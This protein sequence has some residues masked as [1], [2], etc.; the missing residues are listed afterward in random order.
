MTLNI[1]RL[2]DDNKRLV[3]EIGEPLP[4]EQVNWRYDYQYERNGVVANLFM[5]FEP[6]TAWR[7]RVHTT[8]YAIVMPNRCNI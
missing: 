4:M 7:R 1:S 3:A 6:L 2:F 5:F 8:A